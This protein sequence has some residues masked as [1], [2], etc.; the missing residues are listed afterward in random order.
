MTIIIQIDED[1]EAE[2]IDLVM[3]FVEACCE[4]GIEMDDIISSMLCAVS[5]LIEA[6]NEG[7]LH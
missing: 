6:E 7:I 3:D 5:A 4:R 2:S 1:V